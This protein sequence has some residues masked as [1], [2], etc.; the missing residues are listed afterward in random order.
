MDKKYMN[1]TRCELCGTADV[2]YGSNF[3]EC[4]ILFRLLTAPLA[5]MGMGLLSGAIVKTKGIHV[6][7]K[8]ILMAL[9]ISAIVCN[10]GA[11]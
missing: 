9:C 2:I 5:T 7:T 8:I 11:V 10:T 6:N 1:C 4:S 3:M